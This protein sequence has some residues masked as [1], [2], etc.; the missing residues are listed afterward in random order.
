MYSRGFSWN[1]FCGTYLIT[2]LIS[3][4]QAIPKGRFFKHA[5]TYTGSNFS[6]N[7]Y[8][9]MDGSVILIGSISRNSEPES[10][11]N[12]FIVTTQVKKY[13]CEKE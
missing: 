12:S 11:H 10:L 13:Q 2:A 5:Q 8:S 4:S 3:V 1:S 6:S 9:S 7:S